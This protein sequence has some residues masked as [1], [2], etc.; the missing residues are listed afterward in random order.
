MGT[1]ATENFELTPHEL[2]VMAAAALG[3]TNKEIAKQYSMNEQTVK[4]HIRTIFKKLGVC[5]RLEL[6]L[7]ALHHKL[8]KDP[9]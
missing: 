2:K 1:M 8:I 6:T 7:F 9:E 5:N 3:Y 4:R